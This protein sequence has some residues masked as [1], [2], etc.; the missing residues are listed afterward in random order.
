MQTSTNTTE[1]HWS[2]GRP[3]MPQ[4]YGLAGGPGPL[5]PEE[6]VAQ[7][8]EARN[9]WVGTT[10]R[11]GRPHAMPVWGL[12]LGDPADPLA[13]SFAFST[14]PASTKGRN[15]LRDPRVIVHLESGNDV[16]VLEGEIRTL[17]EATDS[18]LV[19]AFVQDYDRK[20]SITV[21]PGP[22]FGLFALT[23]QVVLA[24]REV[25]FPATATRW[26]REQAP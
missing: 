10:R 7:L 25:D 19:S 5:T 24:W 1:S 13:G 20:Y 14:D 2:V 12:W 11:D 23:P 9:Y 16:V 4:G 18:A 22:E 6:V 8:T 21:E 26:S 17:D 3:L 15:L